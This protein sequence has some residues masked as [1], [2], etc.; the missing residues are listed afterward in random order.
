MA[1][2][3]PVH[4]LPFLVGNKLV[5]SLAQPGGNVTGLSNQS[6][7]LAAKRIELL[8]EVVP[9]LGRLAIMINVGNQPNRL[10]D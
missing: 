1:I 8:R 5:A 7:D 6:T 10:S 2:F 4:V 3:P 9:S